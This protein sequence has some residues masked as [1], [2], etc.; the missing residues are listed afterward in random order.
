MNLMRFQASILLKT[1]KKSI[2]AYLV[3]VVK[4]LQFCNKSLLYYYVRI[5][6]CHLDNFDFHLS[7]HRAC[8]FSFVYSLNAPQKVGRGISMIVSFLISYT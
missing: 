2:M 4:Q 8:R 7:F 3:L 1:P 6:R 5:Y